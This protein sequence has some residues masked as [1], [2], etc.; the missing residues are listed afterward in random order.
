MKYINRK[1]TNNVNLIYGFEEE[2]PRYSLIATC[3]RIYN[4]TKIY[5][6]LSKHSL[7]INDFIEFWKFLQKVTKTK[8]IE[9]EAIKSDTKV[10]SVFLNPIKTVSIKTFNGYDAEQLLILT[11]QK[12]KL[13][14]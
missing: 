9:I 14:K 13:N 6:L 3:H 5:G 2:K 10:Y 1:I 8:Y 4:K 11:K 12:I 7:N